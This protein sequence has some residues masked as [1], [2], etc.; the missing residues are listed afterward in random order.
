MLFYLLTHKHPF[1]CAQDL[2]LYVEGSPLPPLDVSRP[3]TPEGQNF[4]RLL[5]TADAT[6]RPSAKEALQDIWFKQRSFDL[7][8]DP[9]QLGISTRLMIRQESTSTASELLDILQEP[10]RGWYDEEVSSVMGEQTMRPADVSRSQ[11]AARQSSTS[12]YQAPRSNPPDRNT[13]HT[14]LDHWPLG[15]KDFEVE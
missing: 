3:V 14:Q 9:S 12:S 8:S 4:L 7:V 2:E 11:V 5:L 10:S 6:T 15:R 1:L 13:F